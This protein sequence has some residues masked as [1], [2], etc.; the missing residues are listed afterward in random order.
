MRSLTGKMSKKCS[1][2]TECHI[3]ARTLNPPPQDNHGSGKGRLSVVVAHRR[4]KLTFN[5]SRDRLSEGLIQFTTSYA[6]F[7][8]VF[9]PTQQ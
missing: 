5:P 2:V 3:N 4:L 1:K 6:P 9:G 8:R 7:M